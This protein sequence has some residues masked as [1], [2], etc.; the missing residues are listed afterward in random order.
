MEDD[1][2][3]R[4]SLG[5]ILEYAQYLVPSAELGQMAGAA[6]HAAGPAARR[7]PRTP[8]SSGTTSPSACSATSW[9]RST[10]D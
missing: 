8:T 6:G 3:K 1:P 5:V 7:G 10:S 9:R 4:I 2:A